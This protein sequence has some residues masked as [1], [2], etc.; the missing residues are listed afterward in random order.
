[1]KKKLL[2]ALLAAVLGTPQVAFAARDGEGMQYTSASEGFYGS[3]RTFY[4]SNTG[5]KRNGGRI[6]ADG[7]RLGLRGTLDLGS[8]LTGLYR[9]EWAV[10]GDN[11]GEAGFVSGN[12]GKDSFKTRLSYVGLRGAFGEFVAGSHWENDYNWV[13]AA[14]DIAS[15]GSG[16][17]APHFRRANSFQY[18]TPDANGFQASFRVMMDGGDENDGASGNIVSGNLGHIVAS[19]AEGES[20]VNSQLRITGLGTTRDIP[21]NIPGSDINIPPITLLMT[22]GMAPDTLMTV[23]TNAPANISIPI[24]VTVALNATGASKGSET[25]DEWA[26]A[27]KY[28]TH[29]FTFG[30]S[31]EVVPDRR[32]FA[33]PLNNNILAVAPGALTPDGSQ[34]VTTPAS[35][36]VVVG[37][38]T[39]N[40]AVPPTTLVLPTAINAAL[41]PVDEDHT[42]WA[43]RAGYGQDNWGINGW[44][45]KHNT[46]DRGISADDASNAAAQAKGLRPEDTTVYSIAGNVDM[47]KFALVGIYETRDNQWGQDDSVFIANVDYK[48]TSRSKAYF[49]YIANDWESNTNK[50]DE[51]RI[52]LRMD[53]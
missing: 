2:I 7:S 23:T 31:Y 36:A 39:T 49:A 30:A 21:A 14:T 46:A 10:S 3:I 8:G 42:F 35:V 1:M 32:G 44:Y 52:G 12:T 4:S 24:P 51:V 34:T 41:S 53:F 25:V 6:S 13:T 33:A 26:L 18:T 27:A 5:D 47:G 50:D 9:Y 37:N 20:V 19:V 15:T 28:S 11:N 38:A 45:G 43:L 48:F 40:V 17:F 29:G 22:T 16:N